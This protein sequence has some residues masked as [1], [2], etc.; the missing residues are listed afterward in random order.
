MDQGQAVHQNRHVIAVVILRPILLAGGVLVD[1]LEAVVVDVLLI[2]EGDILALAGVPP[3]DLHKV[4]LD[5]AGLVL[6]AIVGVGDALAEKPLPLGIGEGVAVQFL[7]L[8]AEV[9]S[10]LRLGVDGKILVSLFAEEADELLFQCGFALVAV[11]TGFV[12]FIFR[13]NRVFCCLGHDV[14]ITHAVSSLKV[15]SLSR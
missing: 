11:G 5:A 3:E 4:L 15:R 12:R 13:D 1:D 10:Q 8:L 2:N 7:Q 6:D 9:G 14:E